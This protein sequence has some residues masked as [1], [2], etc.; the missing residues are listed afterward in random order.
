MASALSRMCTRLRLLPLI[1][2]CSLKCYRGNGRW[3]PPV[4]HFYSSA[5]RLSHLIEQSSAPCITLPLSSF[6]SVS[7]SVSI[8]LLLFSP[9]FSLLSVLVFTLLFPHSNFPHSFFTILVQM[10]F[11]LFLI[12][13]IIYLTALYG[14]YPSQ[15]L[16]FV[17]YFIH[18][19][20]NIYIINVVI[21]ACTKGY[22]QS[23][24]QT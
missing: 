9:L 15:L 24:Q 8:F 22:F 12:S 18:L 19:F 6:L 4:M 11:F 13:L 2:F 17:L 7:T 5:L 10:F 21:T 23:K 16:L 20:S 3:R 1:H 14:I